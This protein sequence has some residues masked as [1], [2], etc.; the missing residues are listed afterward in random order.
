MVGITN[1]LIIDLERSQ[2][3]VRS[4]VTDQR[5]ILSNIVFQMSEE[6]G[7]ISIAVI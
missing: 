4:S 6:L 5:S 2:R 1:Y 3:G 7:V